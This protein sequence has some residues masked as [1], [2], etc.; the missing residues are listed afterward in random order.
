VIELVV[1]VLGLLAIVAAWDIAKRVVATREVSEKLHKRVDESVA[2]YHQ[3]DERFKTLQQRLELQKGTQ[4][5]RMPTALRR[6]L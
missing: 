3:L 2:Y 4:A 1:G 6:G 5:S